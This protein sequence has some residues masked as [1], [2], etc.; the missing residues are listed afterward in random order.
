[1][2]DQEQEMR[3]GN[4]PSEHDTFKIL[5]CTDLH[6]GVHERDPVRGSDSINTLKEILDLAVEHD[7]DFVLCAG[8]LFHEHKPSS[9]S[10]I[11]VMS[12]LREYCL[13]DRPVAIQLLSEPY[14]DKR[15]EITYPAINYE[16][17]NLNVGL[18][19]F[20][21]HG[22]HDD[23]QTV[24]NWPS[25]A[26]SLSAVDHLSTAGLVNYFGKVDVPPLDDA[27]EEPLDNDRGIN[28][29]PILL[30]KGSSKVALFGIGNIRDQRFNQELKNERVNMY[31]P[32]EDADDYF[33]ILLIHQNRI[34]RGALQA[35]PEHLFD[36][37]ISLVV[38]GHEHD[39]RIVPE[40]VSEKPYRITQPG[41]SVATSL[42]EGETVPKHV[43]LLEIHGKD[44][45][46]TPLPLKTVRPFV[47]M[48][49]NLKEVEDERGIQFEDKIGVNKYLRLQIQELI[50]R[51]YDE[52][53]ERFGSDIP[54]DEM[55]LP[56]VRLRVDYTG[57]EIGNPQRLG[58][59][60]S[61]K[62]A[63]PKDLVHFTKKRQQK[64]KSTVVANEPEMIDDGDDAVVDRTGK[65]RVEKLVKT[66]LEAQKLQLLHEDGLQRSVDAFVEKGDTHA[67]GDSVER[68][69]EHA[70]EFM[71]KQTINDVEDDEDIEKAKA[72]AREKY[73]QDG[74]EPA[75]KSGTKGKGRGGARGRAQ[76]N[77]AD[78]MEE[79][80]EDEPAPTSTRGRGAAR[81]RGRGKGK[82]P[83]PTSTARS[84]GASSRKGDE[85]VDESL[86]HSSDESVQMT[87]PPR[88]K[89]TSARAQALSSRVP[90]RRRRNQE[91][92]DIS[93][94][95]E[96]RTR[97]RRK[98]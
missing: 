51:A 43:G 86:F 17:T 31:A 11:S 75:Q 38:W 13:N 25:G 76:Q 47:M 39:C 36:D 45:N 90:Q 63:N 32:L 37:S 4:E 69:V 68:M 59:E 22:N 29:K 21:I 23:P 1:M 78:S 58:M 77:D 30:Q 65:L 72:Y 54:N 87:Q 73:G 8:D 66:F 96:D 5:L 34:N 3:N 44:Y 83:A 60:F 24:P 95:E 19:F 91:V 55:M 53:R 52:Y 20:L 79:D 12:L 98:H 88:S 15:P 57:F 48:D 50:G 94:E 92:Y 35:V 85:D 70:V 67:I 62:V 40:I 42:C 41:S 18:P 26:P 82:T 16:D 61:E 2:D 7:V 97:Q 84:R 46:L 89:S 64:Q 49:V 14:D 74:D 56:L 27:P 6:I 81:G 28:V 9:Q 10:V 80:S 71:S 33:N 93:S